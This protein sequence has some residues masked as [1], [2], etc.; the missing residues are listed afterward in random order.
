MNASLFKFTHSQWIPHLN[1][2]SKTPEN[3]QLVLCFGAKES[4]IQ[5]SIYQNLASEFKSAEIVMC[6]TAGEIYQESV[7]DHTLTA[8]AIEFQ[9]SYIYT[10]S[11]NI[12]SSDIS[13]DKT[14]ELMSKLSSEG[15]QYVMVLSDGSLVNGSEVVRALNDYGSY[16][17]EV[18]GRDVLIT[19]G[20]AGDAANFKSTLVGLNEPPKEGQIVAIGFYGEKLKVSHGTWGGWEGFGLEKEITK[21]EGNILYEIDGKNALELY[22][23]YLGDDAKN[24]PASALLFPLTIKIPGVASPIVRT[25][26][27]VNEDEKTMTFAGN[28]PQGCKVRLMKANFDKLIDAAGRA[29]AESRSDYKNSPDFSLLVSC[30]GRKLVLGPRIEEEVEAVL[31]EFGSDSPIAGFYAY[32]EISPFNQKMQCQLH[33]QTMTITSFYELP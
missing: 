16:L 1:N 12:S 7:L 27:S 6:S 28:V 9:H 11:V 21:S 19:G 24:L 3:A 14:I 13:Y 25:I 5:S 22:K 20:L 26:L 4:L 18:L 17:F 31:E 23:R 8:V 15:L 32:G 2:K 33:N 10:S 29:A 30:V